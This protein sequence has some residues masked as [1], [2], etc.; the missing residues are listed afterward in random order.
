[1]KHTPGPW[2]VK[3]IEP[4]WEISGDMEARIEAP[5]KADGYTP[6]ET[7]FTEYSGPMMY[8]VATLKFVAMKRSN[9]V[10]L[11][12]EG[13]ANARLIA[14]APDLLEI[15]KEIQF[16]SNRNCL[17]P[18]IRKALDAAIKLATNP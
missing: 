15:A 11:R 2:T 4:D 6:P 1:M 13:E 17:G 7:R 14:A 9:F 8:K 18:V 3:V 16:E 12:D 10:I 5:T